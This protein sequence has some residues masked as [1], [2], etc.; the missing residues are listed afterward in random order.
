VAAPE[1][2]EADL[3]EVF[4]TRFRA[5]RNLRGLSQQAVAA[6]LGVSQPVVARFETGERGI[7]A[8]DLSRWAAAVD[9]DLPTMLFGERSVRTA[10]EAARVIDIWN[11]ELA[12]MTARVDLRR[13]QPAAAD[14]RLATAEQKARRARVALRFIVSASK[15]PSDK[16]SRDS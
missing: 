7:S 11:N 10:A 4:R 8:S 2:D 5:A 14:R 13:L 16:R 3:E 15:D 6:R 12:D 9:E 1:N